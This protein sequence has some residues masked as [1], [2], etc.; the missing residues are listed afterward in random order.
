MNLKGALLSFLVNK[1]GFCLRSV[2]LYTKAN[3]VYFGGLTNVLSV[4]PSS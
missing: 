4:F 3:F 1:C 2:L